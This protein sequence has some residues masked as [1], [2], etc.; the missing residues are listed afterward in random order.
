[1]SEAQPA[2][3]EPKTEELDWLYGL[4]AGIFVIEDVTTGVR[5]GNTIR[6]RGHF[7]TDT[8]SAY[9]RL[10]P[11]CRARGRTL[12][13]RREGD[14]E[15]ILIVEGII[16][17]TPN[18]RWLPILLAFLTVF[19]MLF[20]NASFPEGFKLSW[21]G[22]WVG[23]SNGLSFT[24]SFLAILLTH[25]LGHFFV[26]RRF[27]VAVTL[28]YLIPFPLSPF[29]TLGAVI[30]MKSIPPSKRAMLLIGVAGPLA[31][32]L[33]AIPVLLWG[34]H[35]S[36]ISLL[37][38]TGAYSME[39]NSLLYAALKFLTFGRLLPGGGEDV[40]LHPMAM[41]GWAGLLVTSLN[42]I[43]AGQLDGG[44]IA[45]TLLG[46]KARYLNWGIVALLLVMGIW[47]LGWLLWAVII[48][49]FSRVRVPPM[50]DLTPPKRWEIALAIAFLVIFVLT[51]TPI[52][53]K[54]I[55]NP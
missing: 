4:L 16:R 19:S 24:A 36:T 5:G 30:G 50:D 6:L 46:H 32:L 17:P 45:Y 3:W 44:H 51:F 35:L 11:L 23:L 29:G 34:L 41:A 13:F 55:G 49:I 33:V 25:E 21:A 27:G 53:L 1:M 31:G 20:A 12:M 22:I 26:A 37:P 9:R 15:V 14:A 2:Q 10:A 47:W 52:P 38:T 28:P 54:L 48:F 42:L 18:N 43:P 7:I 39:G 40:F 8:A